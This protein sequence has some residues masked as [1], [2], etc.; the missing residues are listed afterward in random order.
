MITNVQ[1][2]KDFLGSEYTISYRT[3]LAINARVN[4]INI[5][6][7]ISKEDLMKKIGGKNDNC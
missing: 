1:Q 3:P 6:F 4:R 7:P 5:D 2:L